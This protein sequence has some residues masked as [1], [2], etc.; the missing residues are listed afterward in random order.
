MGGTDRVSQGTEAPLPPSD[1]FLGRVELFLADPRIPSPPTLALQLFQKTAEPNCTAA[2]LA[3]LICRDPGLSGK[4][5]SVVNSALYRRSRPLTSV[6]QAVSLLGNQRLRSLVLGLALPVMQQGLPQDAGLRRFWTTSVT[7]A[8]VARRI[9]E[10]LGLASPDEEMTAGLLRDLGMI[11][12]RQ[13]LGEEYAPVWMGEID[14]VEQAIWEEQRFGLHHGVISAALLE[15]WQLPEAITLPVR[16]HHRPGETPADSDKLVERA[17]LLY[18]VSLLADL[19]EGEPRPGA[20][21]LVL[22]FAERTYGLGPE[23]LESLLDE[24]LPAIDEFASILGVEIDANPDLGRLLIAG[25]DALIRATVDPLGNDLL[26][27]D[28]SLD[29]EKTATGLSVRYP[30]FLSGLDEF[31]PG[32]RLED[33]ELQELLG[34]G[35]MGVVVKA[36]DL[37]LSRPVAIKFLAP[38]LADNAKA[39]QR[40]LLEAR[41]AAALRHE[42]VVAIYAIREFNGL[43]FIVMEYVDGI[44]LEDLLLE[45]RLTVPEIAKIGRQAA[46]G[47]AAAHAARLIHRDIKPAN[48]LLEEQNLH[49]RVADFGLARAVDEDLNLSKPGMLLGT[50]N[51]MSPEQVDGRPLTFA[52]DLFSLGSVLYEMCTG[53]PPFRADAMSAL[54]HAIALKSPPPIRELNPEI[55]EGLCRI[56]SRLHEKDPQRRFASATDVAAALARYE[57]Y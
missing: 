45:R 50:P 43:P 40:F 35:G 32:I 44:S 37:G 10:Q 33:Y 2:E 36:L 28:F 14:V 16:F 41:Y 17:Q 5:L 57:Q 22:D 1:S 51:Y 27:T 20:V 9:A 13:I 47:L 3:E 38:H 19:Q 52:S 42:N 34:R 53:R 12:M 8:V 7:G 25:C 30:R 49:A 39:K 56:V 15:N 23:A 29:G 18:F 48:I 4:L 46:L 54:L 55:P 26:S 11:A 6:L 31:E 24:V 21:E